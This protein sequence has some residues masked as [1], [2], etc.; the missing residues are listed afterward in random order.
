MVPNIF[1]AD[2]AIADFAEDISHTMHSRHQH[3]VLH[4]AGHHIVP[5]SN[6]RN[7]KKEEAI[8]QRQRRVKEEEVL[9]SL[10]L[11]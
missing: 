2:G 3:A 10:H 4:W 9:S 11:G 6:Q 1:P 7:Q 5:A 8:E